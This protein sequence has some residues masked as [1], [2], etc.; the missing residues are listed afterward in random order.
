MVGCVLWNFIAEEWVYDQQTINSL[1]K[2]KKKDPLKY[3]YSLP[4]YLEDKG[5][6][7]IYK[8]LKFNLDKVPFIVNNSGEFVH[9]DVFSKDI[10]Y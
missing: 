9:I 10:R 8:N 7:F 6:E 2:V 3:F 5:F 1:P 4:K